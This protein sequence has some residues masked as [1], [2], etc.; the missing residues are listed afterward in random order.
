VRDVE[1]EWRQTVD[2]KR[3]LPE[4]FGLDVPESAVS[5]PVELG[6]YLDEDEIPPAP[7]RRPRESA[8]QA[9]NVVEMPVKERREGRGEATR[10]EAP[11]SPVRKVPPKPRRLTATVLRK[12]VNMNPETLHMVDELLEFVRTYSPQKDVKASELF[13]TLV[14]SLYEARA[15]LVVSEIPPRGRWGTPTAQAFP[16]G[17]KNAFQKAIVEDYYQKN[18]EDEDRPKNST[19]ENRFWPKAVFSVPVTSA[20]VGRG[21]PSYLK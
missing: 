20:K 2:K 17:L 3:R 16:V 4:S 19:G 5:R 18:K 15:E 6:D 13:H 8:P 14:L 11:A 1:S 7:P 21:F 10:K 12:Q 9:R